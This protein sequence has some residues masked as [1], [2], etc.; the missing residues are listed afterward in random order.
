MTQDFYKIENFPDLV[1]DA[2]TGAIINKNVTEY[3]SYV[4]TYNRLKQE[5]EELQNLKDDVSSLKSDIGDI[6]NL[7]ITLLEDKTHGN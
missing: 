4:D 5:Q 3:Q 2:S 7:L 1:R 6:K